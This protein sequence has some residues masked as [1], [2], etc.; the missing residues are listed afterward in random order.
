MVTLKSAFLSA[1]FCLATAGWVHADRPER[2][3]E[4]VTADDCHQ[5][6]VRLDF[7]AGTIALVPADITDL[8]KLDIY[9][10]PDAVRYDVDKTVRG[11]KCI[12]YLESERRRGW[13]DDDDS[14]NEW[15]VQLSR[16]IPVSLEIDIGACEARMDLGGVPLT[17]FS[18]DIG[19]ADLEIDFSAPNPKE[20]DDFKVDCGASALEITGLANA[21]ARLMEFDVGVGSC[22]I[23]LRGDIKGEVSLDISVGMGSM[24]V[25]VSKGTAVR[26][27][28]D[29]HWFSDIGFRGIDL[30]KVRDGV[31][32]TEDFDTATD[33]I[34]ISAD[35]AMGSIDIH[36][37]R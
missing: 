21:N 8:V 22:E 27:E 2:V 36:A 20:I 9:Y 30:E 6:E 25:I 31:W 12:V 17:G 16:K 5:A 32:E 11:D 1:A 14:E 18:L 4:V 28:G 15:T 35:V 29:D 7:A 3:T 33:R 23:D 10:T 19:A 26:V 13:G 24:D 37:K 34:V